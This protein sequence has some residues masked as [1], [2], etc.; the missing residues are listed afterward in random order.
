ME[1]SSVMQAR[2]S[3]AHRLELQKLAVKKEIEN[4][5]AAYAKES[6]NSKLRKRKHRLGHA[7]NDWKQNRF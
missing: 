2:Y 1:N 7:P 6:G 4:L 3:D 5:V